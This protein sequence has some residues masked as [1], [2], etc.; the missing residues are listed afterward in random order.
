MTELEFKA[1]LT[2]ITAD[3]IKYIMQKDGF[4]IA[5]VGQV[6]YISHLYE[7]LEKEETKV[8]NYSTPVLYRLLK[9]ELETGSIMFP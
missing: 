5:E 1:F 3:L 8:W 2:V 6:L 4:K 9:E 7:L